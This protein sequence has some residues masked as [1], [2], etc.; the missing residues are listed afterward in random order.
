MVKAEK[1]TFSWDLETLPLLSTSRAVNACHIDFKSS[2]RSVMLPKSC[3]SVYYNLLLR[4]VRSVTDSPPRR[5]FLSAP[6]PR[7]TERG[8]IIWRSVSDMVMAMMKRREELQHRSAR[9]GHTLH[10]VQADLIPGRDG[11]TND[12]SIRSSKVKHF[13]LNPYG[14]SV[15]NIPGRE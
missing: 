5:C 2:S 8:R 13:K 11:Q 12:D 9:E 6:S 4:R 10:Q 7:D 3:V 14:W 15:S 1:L